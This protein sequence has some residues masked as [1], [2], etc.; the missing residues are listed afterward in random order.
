ML[1][2]LGK[3]GSVS[4]EC[5]DGTLRDCVLEFKLDVSSVRGKNWH[6]GEL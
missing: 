2:R 1:R 3:V 4:V 6:S 5:C